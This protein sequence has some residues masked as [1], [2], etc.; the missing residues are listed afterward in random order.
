[1][2]AITYLDALRKALKDVMEPFIPTIPMSVYFGADALINSCELKTFVVQNAPR[3][4]IGGQPNELYTL[5]MIDPDVP[6]PNAPHLGQL[7]SWIVTNIPGGAS[8]TQGTEIMPYV[9]PNPQI[10]V[11]RYILFLYQQQARLD[12]ID[13][14]ES[15]FHFNVEDFAN[16]HNMGN[17]VGLSYFNVRRQANGRNANA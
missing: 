10:G 12:D 8:C 6:N 3:V 16:R 1:M 2:S 4:V 9:G 5:V 13:A 14:I 11:H 7:I 15:R 17:P